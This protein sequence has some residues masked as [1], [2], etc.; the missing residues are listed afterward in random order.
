MIPTLNAMSIRIRDNCSEFYSAWNKASRR[1][2]IVHKYTLSL[3]EITVISG[4]S[5]DPRPASK[6]SSTKTRDPE[7]KKKGKSN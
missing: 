5:F 2:P 7:I 1:T 6:F 3:N 4:T